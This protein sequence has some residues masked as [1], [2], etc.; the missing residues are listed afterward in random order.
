MNFLVLPPEINSARIH[1]GAGAGPMLAAATAWD[2]LADELGSASSSF[3][4]VTSGLV[5]S[6][7]QGPAAM[8]MTAAA[9]PYQGWLSVAA[10]QAQVAAGQARASASAFEAAVSAIVH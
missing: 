10:T 5:E 2:G 9:A 4:L 7:W 1:L 8:A 6:A 3:G